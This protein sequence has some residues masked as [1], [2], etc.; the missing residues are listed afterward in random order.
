MIAKKFSQATV[1]RFLVTSILG[2]T[3]FLIPFRVDGNT[4]VLLGVIA[5][6][7]NASAG[8]HMRTFCAFVFI[9]SA[10]ITPL[11][12][13]GPKFIRQKL[14]GLAITFRAG[15]V[16]TLIRVAGGIFCAM[17]LLSVGPEWIIDVNTGGTAYFI[18]AA[19]IF[20]LIGV[21]AMLMPLLTDYG[22]LEL[23]GTMLSKFFQRVFHLPGRSTIDALASWV[24]S[25][26][27]A[28]LVTSRQYEDGYY[29]A[30]EAAVIATNFSVVSVP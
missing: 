26:S 27:I 5:D 12:T 1:T 8:T 22:L 6:W 30:R 13:Y 17:T 25:S 19:V 10:I 21:G 3:F 11:Y 7:I 16:V 9:T 18:I 28:V 14:P 15:F 2:A 4:K 23:I 24:G 29:T 20:A